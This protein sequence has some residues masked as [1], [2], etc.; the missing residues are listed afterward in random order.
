MRAS[1]Q[2]VKVMALSLIFLLIFTENIFGSLLYNHVSTSLAGAIPYIKYL[3]FILMSITT[4][5]LIFLHKVKINI[6]DVFAL[7]YLGYILSFNIIAT[8]NNIS[9]GPYSYLYAFPVIIYFSGKLFR[10]V[11]PENLFIVLVPTIYLSFLV[12]IMDLIIFEEIFWKE[13]L[14][15]GAYISGAKGFED[16]I[17]DG[18]PGNFYYSPYLLKIRRMVSTLGDPLAYG[19]FCFISFF[20]VSQS[21]TVKSKKFI[22]L[23]LSAAIILTLTRAALIAIIIGISIKYFAKKSGMFYALLAGGATILLISQ[24]ALNEND[25]TDSSTIGHVS[26]IVNIANHL[27]PAHLF[28]GGLSETGFYYYEPGIPNILINYGLAGLLLFLAFSLSLHT[29]AQRDKETLAIALIFSAGV[30]TLMVFSQ[31]FLSTTT[32]W[33]AWFSAGWFTSYKLQKHASQPARHDHNDGRA[34]RHN[35]KD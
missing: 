31:S 5:A 30:F 4:I 2:H 17:V 29:N 32:S 21:E 20:L 26:S 22:L 28:L 27:D 24:G 12:G 35:L 9:T 34:L 7:S 16:T 6:V 18:L 8:A 23:L 11:D 15:Y 1:R 33:L 14:D 25:I 13:I 10:N 3:I 19:Y